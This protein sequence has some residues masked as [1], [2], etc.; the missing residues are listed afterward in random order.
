MTGWRDYE[1]KTNKM[2]IALIGIQIV[3]GKTNKQKKPWEHIS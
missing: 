3:R 2:S 1:R